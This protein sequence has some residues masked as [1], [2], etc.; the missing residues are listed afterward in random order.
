MTH[1]EPVQGNV[2]LMQE[3]GQVKGEGSVSILIMTFTCLLCDFCLTL[4]IL[5]LSLTLSMHN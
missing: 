1:I 4:K 3:P 2:A 5:I